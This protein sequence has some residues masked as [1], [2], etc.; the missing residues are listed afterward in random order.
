M[1]DTENQLEPIGEQ[2]EDTFFDQAKTDEAKMKNLNSANRVY[3]KCVAGKCPPVD[4]PFIQAASA[5]RNK[6]KPRKSKNFRDRELANIWREVGRKQ[7]MAIMDK[8][9][10]EL[11][12]KVAVA[13]AKVHFEQQEKNF[14]IIK[15]KIKE[16]ETLEAITSKANFDI[17]NLKSQIE[18]VRAKKVEMSRDRESDGNATSFWRSKCS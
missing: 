14:K 16:I 2:V 12:T 7:R 11:R 10:E 4:Q 6:K 15:E 8:G 3:R 18:R 9:L 13:E 5:A 1:D 17:E